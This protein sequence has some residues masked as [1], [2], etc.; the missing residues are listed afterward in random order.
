V[1]PAV[2]LV[3]LRCL[4]CDTPVPAEP[5]EIAWACGQCGQGLLL[6][7]TQG[8]VPLAIHSASGIPAGAAGRPFW[9]V[10]GRVA[11]ERETYGS[12]LG[13]KTGEAE[14][15]W[16]APRRFIIPAYR[17]SLDELLATGGQLL[18]QPPAIAPGPAAPFAP[19]ILPPADL[20]A[21]AEFIVLALEAGRRDQ[22][23]KVGLSIQLGEPEL[24]ILP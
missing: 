19:A 22:L 6:D 1:S 9:V 18:L 5:D 24:W 13:N 14:R 23:K 4:R 11:L 21:L 15:F 16:E 2:E 7:E 10:S 20:R 17:C 12:L 8:L 3:P